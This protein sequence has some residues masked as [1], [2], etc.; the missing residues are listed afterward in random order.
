MSYEYKFRVLVDSY[1]CL[2][3]YQFIA[4]EVAISEFNKLVAEGQKCEIWPIEHNIDPKRADYEYR[5]FDIVDLGKAEKELGIKNPK[6]QFGMVYCIADLDPEFH[7]L[8][9]SLEECLDYIDEYH[10]K[11][12]KGET[13]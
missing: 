4:E 7:G 6:D 8:R 9:S 2:S 1:N 12:E 10:Y 5:D 13:V 3:T 11:K